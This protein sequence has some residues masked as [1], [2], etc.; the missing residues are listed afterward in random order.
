MDGWVIVGTKLDTKQLERELRQTERRLKEYEQEAEKLTRIQTKAEIDLQPYEQEKRLIQEVT[1]EALTYAQTQQEVEQVL[2]REQLQVNELNEKYKDQLDSLDKINHK[3]QEN[4]KNQELL[5]N[6]I[7]EINQ[8]IKQNKMKDDMKQITD[9]TSKTLKKIGKWSLAIFGIRSA[10]LFVRQ[11]MSTLSQYNEQMAAD[12][13]YI[14][15]ALASSMEPIITKLVDLVFQLLYY[16]N[17]L[18]KAWFNVDL[19]ANASIDKFRQLN[20]QANELKKSLAGFDEMNILNDNGSVGALGATPSYDLS[21]M[22]DSEEVK[23]IENFWKDIDDFWQEDLGQMTSN[24][25][26]IWGPFMAG[27]GLTGMGLYDVLKGVF[28]LIAGLFIILVGAFTGNEEL[29]SKGWEKF[30]FGLYEIVLGI[31]ELIGG[32]V[33][34][35]VGFILGILIEAVGAINV[36]LVGLLDLIV[37][38]CDWLSNLIGK[39]IDSLSSKGEFVLSTLLVLIKG[40]IDTIGELFRGLS[41]SVKQILDGLIM[42]LQGDFKNG[43]VSLGKGIANVFVT[44]LNTVIEAIN[45]VWKGLLNIVDAVGSLFGK[46]WNLKTKL[47][48]PKIPY[49]AK[50]GIVNMPSRGVPVGGAMAGEA[51]AE[52]VIPLTDSQAMETLG[53]AIGKYITINASITNTMNGRIISRELQKINNNNDFA[54]NR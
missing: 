18:A 16:V 13:E 1:E 50:G 42:I 21:S 23:K 34:M 48:I 17:S 43:F 37:Y 7:D 33:V 44:V 47:A 10:Y 29:I 3:I 19:F 36:I 51:G 26:G 54:F 11:S 49:L 15:F 45:T 52:G 41:K 2:Q 6:T 24:V 30:C 46:Q 12:I 35:I 25:E 31:F 20:K 8:K 14:N 27:L 38:G 40:V 32:L 39:T 28:D 9:Y 5:K 53:Q 4:I 22:L